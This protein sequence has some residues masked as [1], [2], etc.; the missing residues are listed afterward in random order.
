MLGGIVAMQVS[1]LRLNSGI[2]RAVQTQS[3]LERQN[4]TLQARSPS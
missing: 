2:S 4:A 3:T 1:L